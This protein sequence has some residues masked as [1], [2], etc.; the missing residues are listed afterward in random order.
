M[1]TTIPEPTISKLRDA[2][3]KG[4][5]GRKDGFADLRIGSAL[6]HFAGAG[7]MMW[8]RQA[9]RD[10]DMWS[11]IY[12]DS[13]EGDDLTRHLADRYAFERIPDAYGTGYALLNRLTTSGGAGT[14]WK[15]T[16]IRV[17]GPRVTPTA[18]VV[19]E[20]TPALSTDTHLR[21]PI[22]APK[23]GPGYATESLSA[24]VDDPI[25]DAT[26]SVSRLVCGEGTAFEPAAISRARFRDARYDGRVGFRESIETACVAAG[27]TYAVAF[28]SDYAGDAYDQGLNYVY[29]GD[30]NYNGDAALVRAVKVELEKARVLG[31]N[32]QVLPM[33]RTPLRIH[34]Q[35]S[36]W[37]GPSRVNLTGLAR[38]LRDSAVKYFDGA[39]KGFSYNREAIVGG[40]LRASKAV[41]SADI[42]TPTADSN[43]VVST[44]GTLNFPDTL[45]RYVVQETDVDFEFLAA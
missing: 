2:F 9:R 31:D 42:T 15:G 5:R 40:W 44:L 18:F 36:L 45:P 21:V 3:S 13:A 34:A 6:D 1:P 22:R 37:D 24:R 12:L 30:S 7:A 10:S 19:T 23:P 38:V 33:V 39:R 28:Q 4:V 20:D 43:V 35:V 26:W 29:V 11:A 16:R 14:V 27:A 8:A 41:Q 25:W 17:V 32:A